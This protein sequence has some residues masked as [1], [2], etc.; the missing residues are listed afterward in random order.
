MERSDIILARNVGIGWN[1][2]TDECY[3]DD[4]DDEVIIAY[5]NG[6]GWNFWTYNNCPYGWNVLCESIA[7]WMGVTKP[8]L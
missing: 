1:P 5:Y 4:N 2:C 8:Y 6:E 7:Y 3:P